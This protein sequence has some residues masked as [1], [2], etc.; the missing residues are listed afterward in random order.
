M[1]GEGLRYADVAAQ[2][3]PQDISWIDRSCDLSFKM[4]R[5]IKRDEFWKFLEDLG[6][7]IEEVDGI[8][9]YPNGTTEVSFTNRLKALQM[10]RMLWK[11]KQEGKRLPAHR[12]IVPDKLPLYVNWVPTKMNDNLIMNYITE[13]HG[14]PDSIAQLKDNKG[15]KNGSRRII[16]NREHLVSNPIKSYINIRGF[17]LF[18]KHPGQ[19]ETCSYCNEPGHMRFQCPEK[20][21]RNPEIIL[22]KQIENQKLDPK[23]TSNTENPLPEK[24]LS[25]QTSWAESVEIEEISNKG[26]SLESE[27]TRV[28]LENTMKS[29]GNEICHADNIITGKEAIHDKIESGNPTGEI[30]RPERATPDETI[31][32]HHDDNKKH[33]HIRK[34]SCEDEETSCASD[35][36]DQNKVG[37]RSTELCDSTTDHEVFSDSLNLTEEEGRNIKRKWESYSSG[38]FN[39]TIDP[40]NDKRPSNSKH[41]FLQNTLKKI[42]QNFHLEDTFRATNPKVKEFTFHHALG[43][44][45]LDR[46]YISNLTIVDKAYHLSISWADHDAAVLEINLKSIE[47]RGPG[48]WRNNTGHYNDKIFLQ[49]FEDHWRKWITL[50]EYMNCNWIE[51]WINIKT[52]IKKL[53]IKFGARVRRRKKEEKERLEIQLDE[54]RIRLNRGE[55]A[56]NE[57]RNIHGI[58]LQGIKEEIKTPAFA[59]DTAITTRD[60]LSAKRAIDMVKL[61]GNASG[62]VLNL[63]KSKGL[64]FARNQYDL[65]INWVNSVQIVG[66]RY[67]N[68]VNGKAWNDKINECKEILHNI[69]HRSYNLEERKTIIKSIILPKMLY[70]AQTEPLGPKHKYQI[71]KITQNFLLPNRED[72]DFNILTLAKSEGGI[73]LPNIPLIL[74]LQLGKIIL[75]HLQKLH[76]DIEQDK[77]IYSRIDQQIGLSL[78]NYIGDKFNNSKPHTITPLMH[79]KKTLDIIKKYEIDINEIR[80]TPIRAIYDRIIHDQKP[81]YAGKL[82]TTKWENVTNKLLSQQE[83]ILNWKCAHS[84]LPTRAKYRVRMASGTDLCPWCHNRTETE[85]HL[86]NEC[87]EPAKLMATAIWIWAESNE[88]TPPP[89]T[90]K[91]TIEY[92]FG[93]LIENKKRNNLCILLSKMKQCIWNERN[94]ITFNK[95]IPNSRRVFN[96]FKKEII[97]RHKIEKAKEKS[98]DINLQEEIKTIELLNERVLRDLGIT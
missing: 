94:L 81:K 83:M 54:T 26:L 9:Q 25:S 84:I 36:N 95:T 90:T 45:R 68:V 33:D 51:W 28:T 92:N 17:K 40:N 1:A 89:V 10:D 15:V 39:I 16:I 58:R 18:V 70:L 22:R 50:K 79:W 82:M 91:I 48:M 5:Q 46:I 6:I 27:R 52:R 69:G 35:R 73:D 7:K 32:R 97:W 64:C 44:A 76:G 3:V 41:P 13:N 30:D 85:R 77:S 62:M 42:V 87:K 57:D 37:S 80:T 31:S 78:R 66:I 93:D 75:Q 4:K 88:T 43:A 56:I 55:K 53:L 98:F 24:E 34:S 47:K 59:D 60:E 29:N 86:F 20:Q 65:Q 49:E 8:V 71:R 96:K 12:L 23:Q 2:N 63:S 38:D 72:I 21:K 11:L 61:Y 74:D 19:L 14:K 67:G